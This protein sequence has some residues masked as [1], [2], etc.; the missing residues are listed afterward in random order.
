MRNYLNKK[1]KIRKKKNFSQKN[2]QKI[3]QKVNFFT[4]KMN[5]LLKQ[6]GFFIQNITNK[7]NQLVKKKKIFNKKMK[8][9]QNF[10]F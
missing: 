9:F 6:K 1:L 5:N 2:F 4:P 7:Q 3:Y 10:K 8:K